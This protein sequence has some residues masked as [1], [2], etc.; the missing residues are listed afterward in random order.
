MIVSASIIL[1]FDVPRGALFF[2]F[3]ASCARALGAALILCADLGGVAYIMQGSFFSCAACYD[4]S[5]H[6]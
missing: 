3:C 4:G 1:A 6:S 5:E 2:A